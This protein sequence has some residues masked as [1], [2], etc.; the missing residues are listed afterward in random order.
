MPSSR[1]SEEILPPPSQE[2]WALLSAYLLEHESPLGDFQHPGYGDREARLDFW[3]TSAKWFAAVVSKH[4]D[5]LGAYHLVVGRY[6]A[7]YNVLD[8]RYAGDETLHIMEGAGITH[9]LDQLRSGELW[10][11]FRADMFWESDSNWLAL[12]DRAH[13]H[14]GLGGY[15]RATNGLYACDVLPH[16]EWRALDVPTKRNIWQLHVAFLAQQGGVIVVDHRLEEQYPTISV[17]FLVCYEDWF[18]TMVSRRSQDGGVYRTIVGQHL[19]DSLVYRYA[20]DS[21]THLNSHDLQVFQRLIERDSL[22]SLVGPIELFQDK[23]ALR[24]MFDRVGRDSPGE[25]DEATAVFRLSQP[26]Q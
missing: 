19:A 13:Q 20:D 6:K 7:S 11:L 26:G 3:K 8:F 18:A 25:P 23:G 9:Y 12:Y 24:E 1:P 22:W 21:A 5:T 10:K 16:R 2:E 14:I 15:L 17:D 4:S